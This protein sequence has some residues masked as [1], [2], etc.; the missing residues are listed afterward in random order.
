MET[1]RKELDVSVGYSDHTVLPETPAVAVAAGASILEKHFTLDSTL[2]GP[3]HEASLE[4]EEL[5]RAVAL[6][7]TATRIRGNPKKQ[8]TE[9]E[10]ENIRTI[11]KSLHAASDLNSG[12]L[13]EESD[14]SILRPE[15]GLLPQRYG[16]IVGKKMIRSVS[17]GEPIT[18]EDIDVEVSEL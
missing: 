7:H 16:S 10:Q 1:I 11:R 15:E 14:I 6:V 13:L 5:D 17:R 4:P 12:D 3:D 18:I 9:S 8:P 2:P